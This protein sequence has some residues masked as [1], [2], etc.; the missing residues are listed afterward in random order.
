MN[1]RYPKLAR[2]KA[3]SAIRCIKTDG[4]QLFAV[5]G[6]HSQK[7]PSAIRCI[8]TDEG[9]ASV[10]GLPVGESEST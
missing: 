8:K 10:G 9:S 4:H 1:T 2:Q 3:P 7:A 5:G 6:A